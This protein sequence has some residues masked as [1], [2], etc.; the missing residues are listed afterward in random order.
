MYKGK[1]ICGP[2]RTL[3]CFRSI[4]DHSSKLLKTDI[5]VNWNAAML[6]SSHI[7]NIF[8]WG[9]AKAVIR[10]FPA[11]KGGM[12]RI[13]WYWISIVFSHVDCVP[14]NASTAGKDPSDSG[15]ISV[16]NCCYLLIG[17][18]HVASSFIQRQSGGFASG[19]S[20][21]NALS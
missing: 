14:D 7:N 13:W 6:K 11:L 19:A 18:Q 4:W 21:L 17:F 8:A 2:A 1:D 20:A 10:Y 9:N 5:Y 15:T 12:S 16:S 3:Q